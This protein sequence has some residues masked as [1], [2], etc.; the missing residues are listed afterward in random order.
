MDA[1]A[2]CRQLGYATGLGENRQPLGLPEGRP[3]VP[4]WLNGLD[5]RGNETSVTQC[6]RLFTRT[7]GWQ[8]DPV[9][10]AGAICYTGAWVPL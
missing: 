7:W 8:C 6:P 9:S 5:C 1:S 10:L 4:V 3:D 2:L